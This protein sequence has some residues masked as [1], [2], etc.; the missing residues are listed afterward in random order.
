[1]AKYTVYY[2][3]YFLPEIYPRTFYEYLSR[4]F[5]SFENVEIVYSKELAAKSKA[6]DN[7]HVTAF[8][9][10]LNGRRIPVY[11]DWSDF[12]WSISREFCTPDALY[13]KVECGEFHMAKFGMRP[14]G[15][16]VTNSSYFKILPELREIKDA[17]EYD[18]NVF[19]IFRATSGAPGYISDRITA[20]DIISKMNLDKTEISV[21]NM[22][23]RPL[24]PAHVEGKTK[25]EYADYLKASAKAKLN[26][27]LPGI[28]ELTWRIS[29]MFGIGAACIMPKLATNLPGNPKDCWIECKRD[30]SDLEKKVRY[31]L[32]HDDRREAIAE[33]AR[34]YYEDWLSP[35]AQARHILVD[36]ARLDFQALK[37]KYAYP[38]EKPNAPAI[39]KGWKSNWTKQFLSLLDP[40]KKSVIVE[41][42]VWFGKTSKLFLK[43]FP[44]ATLIS[45]DTFSGGVEHQP[46]MAAYE[47][48]LPKLFD[49]FRVNTWEDRERVIPLRM[50]SWQGL[51]EIWKHNIK[52]DLIYIDASHEYKDVKLD[53]ETAYK[54]FPYAAICGDD[55]PIKGVKKA[56]DEFEINSGVKVNRDGRFWNLE[57]AK[58]LRK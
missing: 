32:K 3:S 18:Y 21:L 57:N 13:Y 22:P 28:G 52:P 29:E 39:V 33:N 14:I 37:T 41:L 45:V 24:A 49:I 36:I 11:Y 5:D 40:A 1:M 15:Q 10:E 34:R 25:Y 56:V 8:V 27:L 47:P 20:A 2:P 35:K 19:G 43:N 7:N 16:G 42:G 23:N 44:N 6:S 4:G 12:Q 9:V 54:L 51:Y 48:E 53:L 26:L 17:K 38:L 30:Y 31:Y 50:M 55:Y 58:C 46:G